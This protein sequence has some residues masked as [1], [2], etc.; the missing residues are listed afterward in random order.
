MRNRD[1]RASHAVESN[2]ATG[3]FSQRLTPTS[4]PNGGNE[5]WVEAVIPNG[6]TITLD[7]SLDYL[8]RHLILSGTFIGATPPNYVIPNVTGAANLSNKIFPTPKDPVYD[9]V[10]IFHGELFYTSRGWDG[11][12]E[13]GVSLSDINNYAKPLSAN[14]RLE[15]ELFVFVNPFTGALMCKNG[16]GVYYQTI[17]HVKASPQLNALVSV[18]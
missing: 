18:P 15:R 3:S 2:F 13:R 9:A 6:S 7:T 12:G 4:W 14:S 17:L 11:T 1:A 10:G 8:D 5:I 16:T